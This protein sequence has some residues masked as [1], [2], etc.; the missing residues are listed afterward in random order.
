MNR[1][2]VAS[3][4]ANS[5]AL[6]GGELTVAGWARSV[7]DSKAVGFVALNDGSCFNSLQV[8]LSRDTLPNYD[9]I[10]S[11]NVGAA[12]VVT[13]ELVLTPGAQQPFELKAS[14]VEVEGP[15]APDY[16]LQKK[17]HTVEYLRT[18][19]HLRP[20]TNLFSAVFRVRSQ[21]AY[22]IHTFFQQRG[23]VY[24]NTP[25]I[26]ASDCEGAGEMFRVT[27]LDPANP[28]LDDKGDVDF[29]QDFFG[30]HASLTVSGQLQGE[31]FAM[32]FGSIYTFGP[33]FRAENSNTQRH[34]AEFW[35]VEPEIAFADLADDMDLAEDMLKFVI[36][37]VMQN[38]PDE[39]AFFNSFVDKGLLERL[40]HVVGSD[41]GRIS[42]T[43]AV[44][45]LEQAVA[46]GHEFEYP[47]YWGC[48]L[49]T[50]HE[51]FLTE[52]HFKR[53][54]FVTDYPAE[55]KA[56]YMRM[57][58]DG[59][60]VAA[61][62]CLV[63]GIGEIIGGSQREERLEVLE[64]RIRELGMDPEQYRYYLD[65]RRY[66]SC[67]HAGFGLGFERLVMYLTGV[68]NIRDVLPHPRT[69]GNAEF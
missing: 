51:R 15:S 54:V 29:S 32:A 10:A 6:G 67:R 13:G 22:A 58:D 18:I 19:Q 59:K 62:D 1:T 63:P 20:R 49:A 4:F 30:K 65:L 55:I 44:A 8:V 2:T 12:L 31:N 66:G 26:T 5:Q 61:A 40:E 69:V 60:T 21:A 17:R 39:L 7:R 11:Q 64:G 56:F 3:I 14:S 48:D 50:E 43:D 68:S 35:M 28:P 42:Y 27:T 52:Q 25:I 9:Q 41:F 16:P 37:D 45:V 36:H 57:N 34:A 53:P 46:A 24:V 38:C 23:F 47:V 33:T